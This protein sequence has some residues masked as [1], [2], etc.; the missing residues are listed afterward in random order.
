MSNGKNGTMKLIIGIIGVIVLC[1]GAVASVHMI[2]ATKV[3]LQEHAGSEG[4]H[5]DQGTQRMLGRI[6]SS[7]EQILQRLE[8]I[9]RFL[10]SD[11][12]GDPPR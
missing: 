9:E 8:R 7:N 5:L 4:F 12:D 3:D 10:D 11:H 2:F 6:E 1:A